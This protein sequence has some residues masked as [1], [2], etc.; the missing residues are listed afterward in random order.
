MNDERKRRWRTDDDDLPSSPLTDSAWSPPKS[1]HRSTDEPPYLSGTFGK[2]EVESIVGQGSSSTVYAAMDTNLERKVAL[3]IPRFMTSVGQ[4]TLDRFFH[5]AQ[6]AASLDHPSICQVL[7]AGNVDEIPYIAMAFIEGEPLSN[8]IHAEAAIPQANCAE[9]ILK[10]ATA[11]Q[12]A[13]NCG[14][15][16]LDLK[17]SNIMITN[18]EQPI[19]TDFDHARI[20][21]E[22]GGATQSVGYSSKISAYLSPEQISGNPDHIGLAS[23]IYCLGVILYEMLTKHLPYIGPTDEVVK[24]VLCDEPTPPSKY[25]PDIDWRLLAAFRRALAKSPSDRYVSMA[26]FASAMDDFLKDRSSSDVTTNPDTAAGPGAPAIPDNAD[27]ANQPLDCAAVERGG[28]EHP[29]RPAAAGRA[30]KRPAHARTQASRRVPRFVWVG[31]ASFLVLVLASALIASWYILQPTY[32]TVRIE[33]SDLS[34]AID[35]SIDGEHIPPVVMDDP[36]PMKTGD[37]QLEAT[38]RQYQ[39]IRRSFTVEQDRETTVR[40]EII[41]N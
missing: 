9:I 11:M 30:H 25:R 32:G 22:K 15:V 12:E 28:I 14:I 34:A 39:T 33:F 40:L 17:P 2:Y 10:L 21:V 4:E 6:A 36:F 7:G 31:L 38:G 18:D 16:H 26:E 20:L 27:V 3:K 23:D 19:I 5:Q 24:M 37:H 41:R 1:S 8:M 29:G 13:H 35:V